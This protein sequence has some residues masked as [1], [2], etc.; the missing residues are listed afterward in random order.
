MITGVVSPLPRSSF[1]ALTPSSF[2]IMMSNIM[3]SYAP[4]RP[5]STADKPSYTA[6]TSYPEC[7]STATRAIDMAFSSSAN[8]SFIVV[9]SPLV[10][11]MNQIPNRLHGQIAG[12]Q[13][14]GAA[15]QFPD[16]HFGIL[17]IVLVFHLV[18]QAGP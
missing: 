13:L 4:E 5:F 12:R 15:L 9:Y 16:D 1:S 7:S 17:Y 8:N 2:G 10:V 6:S 14:V 18:L 3:Q 11:C